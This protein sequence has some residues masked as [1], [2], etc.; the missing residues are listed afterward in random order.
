[1][2]HAAS[3]GSGRRKDTVPNSSGCRRNGERMVKEEKVIRM[4]KMASYEEKEGK[5]DRA[6][7]GYFR[8]D[9]IGKQLLISF[10]VITVAFLAVFGVY[11]VLNFEEVMADIYTIDL[12]GT[13]KR[14]LRIYLGMLAVYLIATYAVYRHRYIGARKRLNVLLEYLNCLDDTEDEEDKL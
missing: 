8:G 9:Y 4:T 5:K 12:V 11:L 2:M 1:M 14:I 7:V 13:G 3:K 10:L 6:V